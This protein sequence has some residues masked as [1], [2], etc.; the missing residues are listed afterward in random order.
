MSLIGG[1]QYFEHVVEKVTKG[2]EDFRQKELLL[3]YEDFG[4]HSKNE[5][6]DE[7]S[8]VGEKLLKI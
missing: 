4:K 2:N 1:F 8:I 6:E 3:G 5:S 7:E